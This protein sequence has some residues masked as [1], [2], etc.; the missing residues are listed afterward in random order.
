M[1]HF[2]S[3]KTEI[4]DFLTNFLAQK[5][6]ELKKTAFG[7]DVFERLMPLMVGGKMLRGSLLINTYQKLAGQKFSAAA[8]QAAVSLELAGTS[9]LVHDDIIDQDELRRGQTTLHHQYTQRAQQKNYPQPDHVGESMAICVGDLLFFLAYELLSGDLVK[10]FSE[11]FGLVALGEMHD[12]ELAL[13]SGEVAKDDILQMYEDK[14]ASYSIC[15]PLMA[16]AVLAKQNQE[17]VVQLNELSK[18]LGL[19]FQIKDDELGLFG[20]EQQTG[21]PVGADIREGKKTLYYYYLLQ[22][23][24][25]AFTENGVAEI[26]ELM[27]KHQIQQQVTTD[28]A[29]LETKAQQQ[30]EKLPVE[31]KQMLTQFL[32]KIANRIR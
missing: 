13:M 16:G 22:K 10:L 32:D 26:M 23:E 1:K 18:T 21:K 4:S 17:L 30:L 27:K 15:L 20:D 9:F 8:L 2:I 28:L 3:Y 24:P 29:E 7:E 11:Q 25:T 5:Q 31:L 19:I 14:T 6:Q 12:V